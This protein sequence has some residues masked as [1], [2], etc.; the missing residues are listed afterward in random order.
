MPTTNCFRLIC[1]HP[2]PHPLH[3]PTQRLPVRPRFMPHVLTHPLGCSGA[4]KSRDERAG[5]DTVAETSKDFLRE[6]RRLPVCTLEVA[7]MPCRGQGGLAAVEDHRHAAEPNSH[8]RQ[9]QRQYILDDPIDCI[10]LCCPRA[11]SCAFTVTS[12]EPCFMFSNAASTLLKRCPSY[13][14][15]LGNTKAFRH[16]TGCIPGRSGTLTAV[17]RAQEFPCA[18]SALHL[19]RQQQ[20]HDR[21][22]QDI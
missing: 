20:M 6:G 7:R 15:I 4:S 10:R 1:L 21:E 9:F 12:V 11:V 16:K 3:T 5:P 2:A 8:R 13:T 14:Q 18:H 19:F 22:G 17:A